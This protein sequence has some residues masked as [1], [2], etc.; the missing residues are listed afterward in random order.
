MFIKFLSFYLLFSSLGY[1]QSSPVVTE[2]INSVGTS[3]GVTAFDLSPYAYY[4]EEPSLTGDASTFLHQQFTKPFIPTY[5][6]STDGRIGMIPS[7]A[8]FR[9]IRPEALTSHLKDS[10]PGVNVSGADAQAIISPATPDYL[11]NQFKDNVISAAETLAIAN[12]TIVDGEEG[13]IHMMTMCDP[14]GSQENT[15]SN[16]NPHKCGAKDCYDLVIVTGVQFKNSE[17]KYKGQTQFW[18]TP[19][20][21]EVNNPKT[22]SASISSVVPNYANMTYGPILPFKEFLEPVITADGKLIVGRT[23]G[24]TM[25]W[26]V[27]G[28][29]KRFETV[30]LVN[31]TNGRGCDVSKWTTWNPISYAPA[32]S[33]MIG[34][35]G[36]ADQIFRD[37]EGN[38]ISPGEE[39]GANYPW[40]DKKGNNIVFTHMPSSFHYQSVKDGLIKH[41][42]PGLKALPTCDILWVADPESTNQ[43]PT[44][45][46]MD[47]LNGFNICNPNFTNLKHVKMVEEI[48]RIKGFSILGRWTN[49]KQVAFDNRL[50][51]VDYGFGGPDNAQRILPLYK[52]QNSAP[53]EVVLGA[54]RSA[55]WPSDTLQPDSPTKKQPTGYAG[56]I[57]YFESLENVHNYNSKLVPKSLRDIVWNVSSGVTTDELVFDDY[58]NPDTLI[59]SEMTASISFTQDKDL[60]LPRY[61]DGFDYNYSLK[62]DNSTY[63]LDS[64]FGYG[65]GFGAPIHIQ[66]S[67]TSPKHRWLIPPYG[68][69]KGPGRVEPVAKGGIKGK[70]FWLG[71]STGIEYQITYPGKIAKNN[72]WYIGI[73]VDLRIGD[74]TERRLLTFPDKSFISLSGKNKLRLTNSNNKLLKEIDI[75]SPTKTTAWKHFGFV[76][77]NNNKRVDFYLDGFLHTIFKSSVSI[78]KMD[79]GQLTIGSWNGQTGMR[80][81]I[82]E[83]KVIAQIPDSETICNHARGTL[84]R[85]TNQSGNLWNKV[86]SYPH[87][88]SANTWIDSIISS[89]K[90]GLKYACHVKYDDIGAALDNIPIGTVSIRKQVLFPEGSF[91][92]D[93]PKQD[94]SNNKFCISCHTQDA[95]SAQL[96]MEALVPHSGNA[97]LIDD[98]RRLPTMHPKYIHGHLPPQLNPALEGECASGSNGSSYIDCFLFR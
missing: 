41:R 50:N 80:G 20:H 94:F 90:L 68:L 85:F 62:P 45:V 43:R 13:S 19:I 61:H 49:G 32:D 65:N 95:A 64:G 2:F 96:T 82:D 42:Y 17:G 46:T 35:Y 57:N 87:A 66:N 16:S 78:F 52:G 37:T 88:N 26:P 10:A 77:S 38:E 11:K 14:G 48:S 72:P 30:Y 76:L 15:E 74:L 29:N 91:K 53:V 89:K 21:V 22:A 73:F 83:F 6:T 86:Q 23:A 84:V 60:K 71:G 39:F 3:N 97:S 79:Q 70:G 25:T 4:P 31:P 69:V 51:N 36:I 54:G 12:G 98:P 5:R 55:R 58:I 27:T 34:K 40:I 24:S 7:Q 59:N 44:G 63:E 92:W 9:I 1:A 75:T 28:E 8:E 67:A 93:Q 81:W 33:N 56:N 47:D 18:A